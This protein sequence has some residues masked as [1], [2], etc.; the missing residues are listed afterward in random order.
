MQKLLFILNPVAGKLIAR[1][2]FFGVVNTFC[3]AGYTVT[4][5]ITQF[6][7]HGTQLAKNAHQEGYELIVCCGGDGT[8][9]EVIT[10]I[11]Q[12]GQP[13]PL[14]Y[15]PTGSTN[16][17]ART[18]KIPMSPTLASEAIVK[19]N[20]IKIDAGCFNE[21][22]YFAYIASFGAF[23]AVSYNASQDAKNKFG[24][25]AY[26][27]EGLK[28]IPLIQ[29]YF[30]EL[31]ADGKKTEGDFIFGAVTNTTSVAGIVKINSTI[32]DLQDGLFET[33]LVKNPKTPIELNKIL[34]GITNSNFNNDMFVF[35]KAKDIQL[36]MPESIFWTLD[37]EKA[38]GGKIVNIHNIPNALTLYR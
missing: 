14:G 9:N 4:T 5:Q 22:H 27:V 17:F 32:V 8:L 20:S 2:E 35:C 24:H 29:P 10:G 34:T 38:D 6:T 13:M 18:L 28:N 23:S 25:F 15:I 12:S 19:K 11:L 30:V 37:G 31:I 16:D 26:L 7:G 21:N 3:Y 33:I 36:T 1:T